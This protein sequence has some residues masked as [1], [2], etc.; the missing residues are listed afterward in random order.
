MGSRG[1]HA[2]PSSPKAPDGPWQRNSREDTPMLDQ[3]QENARAQAL[4]DAYY[5]SLTRRAATENSRGLVD[6]VLRRITAAEAGTRKRQRRGS[7]IVAFK[8]VVEGFLGDLLAARGEGWV[9]RRDKDVPAVTISV[10][11]GKA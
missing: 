11:Q 8:H 4:R 6:E 10:R 7:R 1:R 3:A 9:F 5:A 2:V